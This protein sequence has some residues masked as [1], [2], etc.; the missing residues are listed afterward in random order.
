VS[1][2]CDAFNPCKLVLELQ[3][4]GATQFVS[5]P[6]T[7][8]GSP[9]APSAVTA[10]AG[11]TTVDL[12]W[13]APVN[14]GTAPIG[15][16][17]ITPS[18]GAV[19]QAPI[20]TPTN[21]T[22]FTVTGLTNFT[23]YTFTVRRR[24]SRPA[25]TRPSSAPT[26]LGG[27]DAPTAHERGGLAVTSPRPSRTRRWYRPDFR[28]TPTSAACG[29]SEHAGDRHLVHGRASPTARP[30]FSVA[31][32]YAGGFGPVGAVGSVTPTARS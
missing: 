31:A 27:G 30:T 17:V 1:I 28:I 18:I 15:A 5:F 20:T 29:T 13:T 16:Y 19:P 2:T 32:H 25:A 26:Q 14:T 21:P 9:D 11:D 10:T 4:P 8:A 22:N 3:V 23:A 6:L 24:T 12:S 7:Y